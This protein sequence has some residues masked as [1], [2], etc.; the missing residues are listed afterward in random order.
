MSQQTLEQ[1]EALVINNMVVY[2]MNPDLN[3][4]RLW[5]RNVLA[6]AKVFSHH[7]NLFSNL[8]PKIL[9]QSFCIFSMFIQIEYFGMSM[10]R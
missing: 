4:T 5:L 9:P 3:N 10:L 7:F 1:S 8:F 6:S 2:P